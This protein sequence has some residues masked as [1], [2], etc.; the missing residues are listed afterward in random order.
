MSTL[1]EGIIGSDVDLARRIAETAGH[2]LVTLQKSGLFEGKAL[3]KAGDR[4]ANAFIMEALKQQRPDDAVLSEEE[5]DNPERL[6]RER[7]WIVDPL[8]GTREYGEERTDWAVHVALAVNGR[9]T[10]G[11]VALPG[12]PLTLCTERSFGAL[13]GR[14]K[15]RMLVS[16]TRPAREAVAVA[17]KLGAELVPMGSAG[18]K[19]MAVVRGE[20]EIYLHSGGQYEWDSCAPVA[21]AQA[22]GLHVS[23]IDGSPLV[24]NQADVYLPDLLICPP[25]YADQV[26]ALIRELEAA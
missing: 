10:V 21:V 20:A 16:R 3:G 5:K 8:D 15:P 1:F 13:V 7:V 23:R 26:L 6:K 22:A 25:S 24:Y 19:A 9:A 14:G 18:A 17:E 11:A 4:V 12:I 2:I